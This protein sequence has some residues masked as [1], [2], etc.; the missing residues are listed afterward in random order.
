MGNTR[1]PP[2]K[3]Q[4]VSQAGQ[5]EIRFDIPRAY[6]GGDPYA[7]WREG[8]PGHLLSQI[9]RD[10]AYGVATLTPDQLAE[11]V[12][13]FRDEPLPESVRQ[14][15]VLHLRGKRVRRQ[16]VPKK[17]QSGRE[18]IELSILPSVYDDALKRAES[19]RSDLRKLGRKQGRYDD[20]DRL[21]TASSMACNVV[22]KTLP[23]LK[24][25]RD[26]RLLNLVSEVRALLAEE[27]APATAP[28]GNK[29]PK[30]HRG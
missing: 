17:R 9:A 12:E 14:A 10:H 21:P 13:L 18:L 15:V 4:D 23:T 28:D 26:R 24:A 8:G 27:E 11:L 29:T 5:R 1:R 20:P 25:V 30:I 16:G 19:E 22:R 7:I 2:L 3:S 6:S